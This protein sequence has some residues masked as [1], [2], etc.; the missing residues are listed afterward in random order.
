[1]D[2]IFDLEND[3][4]PTA[5]PSENDQDDFIDP[6][7]QVEREKHTHLDNIGT[8]ANAIGSLAI[9]PVRMPV[10]LA[11]N[12]HKRLKKNKKRQSSFRMASYEFDE[13]K[14]PESVHNSPATSV[15]KETYQST[16]TMETTFDFWSSD[17]DEMALNTGNAVM[18]RS[19]D[20]DNELEDD[21]IRELRERRASKLSRRAS[22]RSFVAHA[23]DE[24]ISIVNGVPLPPARARRYSH[25][26][27]GG[28]THSRNSMQGSRRSSSSRGGSRS[29]RESIKRESLRPYR[30]SMTGEVE[31]F[32]RTIV[33]V[34]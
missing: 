5:S 23:L 19:Y 3:L 8:V 12:T 26:R 18:D 9:Q 20:S 32:N 21:P 25:S 4:S 14:V 15:N 13:E 11:K 24:S 6:Y 33:Q 28:S 27:T 2:D 30:V 1:M 31:D 29:S 17:D 34:E 22:R 16:D 7:P 10:K